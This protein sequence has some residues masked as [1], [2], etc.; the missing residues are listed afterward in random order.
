M[1]YVFGRKFAA[2]VAGTVVTAGWSATFTENAIIAPDDAAYDGQELVV[3]GCTVSVQG[4]HE[5]AALAVQ[6]PAGTGG[7]RL[8]FGPDARLTISGAVTLT[9]AST[10]VLGGGATLETGGR[11]WLTDPG[12]TVLVK[13]KNVDG[14]VGD[15]WRAAGATLR[16]RDV[17]VGA[18]AQITADA[19]GYV[20]AYG[21]YGLGPGAGGLVGAGGHGGAGSSRGNGGPAYGSALQPVEVGS[22][23]GGVYVDGWL[24]GTGG[25]G[26]GAI[27]LVVE[28]ELTL[29]GTISANAGPGGPDKFGGGAGGSLWIETGRLAGHGALRATGSDGA[30]AGGGGGGGRIAVYYRE[31]AEYAGFP[32][33]TVAG[34]GGGGEPSGQPGTLGFFDVSR[35][36]G[37]PSLYVP[38]D[39][40]AYPPQAV[41]RL[42]HVSVGTTTAPEAR[43]ELG[44]GG[45]FTADGMGITNGLVRA[46]Q[47]SLLNW[48]G[49]VRLGPAGVFVLGGGSTLNVG[50]TLSLPEPTSLLLVQA[51]NVTGQVDGRWQAVGTTIQAS[52]VI[53]SSGARISADAQGYVGAYGQAGLGPGAN[54]AVGAGG[55]G[56]TGAAAGAGGPAYGS[57]LQ[58]RDVGSSGG[59]VYVDGWRAGTGGTGGGAIHLVVRNHLT[60]DG[61]ISAN[62]GPGEPDKF[63]GGAGGSLWVETGTLEGGGQ[64]SATGS[65]GGEHSGGGGGGRIAVYYRAATA[66]T[67]YTNATV[68]AGGGPAPG[69]P[70]T[71]LFADISRGVARPWFLVPGHRFEFPAEAA[72]GALTLGLAG[73]T[74]VTLDLP[75]DGV[76]RLDDD[77][78]VAN[79]TVL[80]LGGGASLNVGGRL[81]I[82]DTN[83]TILVLGK[84]IYGPVDG[85]WAG[86]GGTILASEVTIG[87]GARLTAD[88]QGYNGGYGYR[89]YG[90]GAN[91][92]VGG[93][94]HGGRGVEGGPTYGSADFPVDLGSAGGGDY[95]SGWF[96]GTGGSGGGALR[97]AVRNTLVVDGALTVNGLDAGWGNEAGGGAGGSLWIDARALGGGGLISAAGGLGRSRAGGGGRI[98]LYSVLRDFPGTITVAGGS[99]EVAA[100]EGTLVLGSQPVFRWAPTMPSAFHGTQALAWET[101]AVDTRGLTVTITASRNGMTYTVGTSTEVLLGRLDWDT[102]TVPD[103]VHELR[104]IFR[105]ATG[106]VV[107]DLRHDALVANTAAVVWHSGTLADDEVWTPAAMHVVDRDLR[108]PPGVTL[109]L[110]P[111]T[112]V[113]ILDGVTLT[114]ADTATLAAPGAPGLP[115]ILTSIQDD[116]AGGDTNQDG[117]QTRP[118]PGSWTWRVE[119]TGQVQVNADTLRRYY[120]QAHAGTL[121]GDETWAGT[122]LHLVAQD[123]SIPAG[124]TLTIEPGAV[125]KFGRHQGLWV[126]AGATLAAP[127]TVAQPITFTSLADATAGG[128][129]ATDRTAGPPGAGDWRGLQLD[130]GKATLTHVA[131]TYAG[132]TPA[133]IW[134]SSAGAL[135]LRNGAAATLT[136]CLVQDALFDGILA[137]GSGDV[138]LAGTVVRNCDRAVNADHGSRVTLRHCVLDANRIGI[139]GHGG[140]VD[141]ANSIISRSAEMG[142][143]NVLGS[144]FA[145]R[146]SDV[147]STNGVNY[148]GTL[149]DPTGSAGNL[150]ADPR[151]KNPVAGDYRLAYR[152][153][154]IDAADG[155]LAPAT[156]A[157]GAPRYSDPRTLVKT[158]TPAANGAFPDLGA[159]EFVES[160]DSPIDLVVSAI[161]APPEA[162]A[163]DPVTVVWTVANL[164][165]AT[166]AGPWHDALS[167]EPE[168][169]ADDETGIP[170]AEVL[171]EAALGPGQSA[172]FRATVRMPGGTEGDWRWRV[173]TNSRGELFEGRNHD[174]NT[175]LAATSTRLH[176]PILPV[177]APVT[178]TFADA[179][180]PSW[181]RVLQPAGQALSV[182][183]DAASPDGRC[184]LYAG[185]GQMPAAH[186]YSWRS[187]AWNSPDAALTI[188]AAAADRV[189]Y[190]TVQPEALAPGQPAFT[191]AVQPSHFALSRLGL[192]SAGNLGSVTL[193][194]T[195]DGF[196]PLLQAA[197]HPATGPDVPAG[198]VGVSSSLDA[199]A[200]FDLRGVPPGVYSVVLTQAG[201]T[202]LLPHAF[203]VTAGVGGRL[204]TRLMLPTAAR[205]GRPFT[206]S[207]EYGNSGDADLAAP[208]LQVSAGSP[209]LLLWEPDHPEAPGTALRFLA[210]APDGLEPGVLRPASSYTITLRAQ[211]NAPGPANFGL[212]VLDGGGPPVD[213]HA[214]SQQVRPPDADALW[215]NAWQTV[216]GTAG[217]T[218][219][220]YLRALN[221][222]ATRARQYTVNLTSEAELLEFL[223]EE[224]QQTLDPAP[225]AGRLFLADT[226]HP[227]ARVT[228]TLQLRDSAPGTPDRLF[229][230]VTWYDGRF[231]MRGVLPGA[232]T[233]S[234]VDHLPEPLAELTLATPAD[235]TLTNLTLIATTPGGAIVGRVVAGDDTA[236]VSG[237]LL[238]ADPQDGQPSH[239]ALTRDDGSYRIPGLAPG[240][241]RLA[242]QA[243]GHLPQPARLVTVQAGLATAQSYDLPLAGGRL[244]GRVTRPD[245]SAAAGAVVAARW[246]GPVGQ[247]GSWS[248]GYATTD[249][250][251][252]YTITGLPPGS[253]RLAAS[254]ANAGVS[255]ITDV[256][257]PDYTAAIARDLALRW[258]ATLS[259]T[260][261][262]AATR[263]PIANANVWVRALPAVAADAWT[264]AAGRFVLTGLGVDRYSVLASADG[265]L[266]V[267]FTGETGAATTPPVV[268]E[269]ERLGGVS[270]VLRSQGT[271]QRQ[272][273][274]T[275]EWAGGLRD[276]VLTDDTGAYRFGTLPPGAYR[277]G[278][279]PQTGLVLWGDPF[280]IAT[281]NLAQ[282]TRDFAL[283]PAGSVT[284]RT[285]AADGVTA[286]TNITVYLVSAGEVLAQTQTDPA[287]AYGFTVLRPGTYRLYAISPT[288]WLTPPAEFTLDT[289][290]QLSGVDLVAPT[291]SLNVLIIAQADGRPL[292]QAVVTLR[293]TDAPE[294]MLTRSGRT[295]PDGSLLLPQVPPGDYRLSASADGYAYTEIPVSPGTGLPG[296]T[297]PLPTGRTIQGVVRADGRPVP[298]V[299][300][301]VAEAGG[302]LMFATQTDLQGHYQFTSLPP[303]LVDLLVIPARDYVPAVEENV[304]TE[305]ANG[306][307]TDFALTRSDAGAETGV[308][309]DSRGAPAAGTL[310]RL[311]HSSGVAV[312]AQA[313]N[314]PD[315]QYRLERCP[316]GAFT[317]EARSPGSFPARLTV[318]RRAGSDSTNA[319]LILDGPVAWAS[320]S[321]G[322]GRRGAVQLADY[323]TWMGG[324]LSG[325]SPPDVVAADALFDLDGFIRY[326]MNYRPQPC[327]V[328]IIP[329]GLPFAIK[330][331][332]LFD[333]WNFDYQLMCESINRD[334]LL[335]NAAAA[336][337]TA[338]AILAAQAI[339]V[340]AAVATGTAVATAST[341]VWGTAL[342]SSIATYSGIALGALNAILTA[343]SSD[344]EPAAKIIAINGAVGSVLNALSQLPPWLSQYCSGIAA[345]LF[346]VVSD[347][348]SVVSAQQALQED[349][350]RWLKQ[351]AD[352]ETR[353]FDAYAEFQRHRH[354]YAYTYPHCGGDGGTNST[355]VLQS[356]DPNAKLTTG[357][358]PDHWVNRSAPITYTIEFENVPTATAAAQQVT[359]TDQ[360]APELDWSTFELLEVAFNQVVVPVP[361]GLRT[362]R[363]VVPVATDPNPVSLAATLNPLTGIATWTLT[364]V[365]PRTGSLVEDPLAG[366]LPPNTPDHRGEGHVTFSIRPRPDLPPGTRILNEARIVF[367]VN[368]PIPTGTVTNTVAA[369]SPASRVA[370][371]PPLSPPDIPVA[372]NGS[373]ANGPGIAGYDLYVSTDGSP[374]Q[375]WLL[376]VLDENA[377]FSGQPGSA[378]AFVSLAWDA[379]GN[380]EALPDVPDAQT[381]VP[382]VVE[383]SAT[384]VLTVKWRSVPG[385]AYVVETTPGTG[386]DAVW[387]AREGPVVATEAVSTFIETHPGASG[388]YRVQKLATP[389]RQA[390]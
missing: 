295:A 298:A 206:V 24:A 321:S 33:C 322:E 203:T 91:G 301:Y 209:S 264:D 296:V 234:A 175:L 374:Y 366:F 210:G 98:A 118:V 136:N 306:A 230:A 163:G 341:A 315:G 168:N 242:I 154:C 140:T 108:V 279:G 367:D 121:A 52:N 120:L 282:I 25:T 189:I 257:V 92:P 383:I 369:G 289:N 324:W 100:Q 76:L 134:D 311:V 227:L 259:G 3:L 330:A 212:R 370:P 354:E 174:N 217:P 320:P 135:A 228:V 243:N 211:A 68:A 255:T 196:T 388:F 138:T 115:I 162:T 325:T 74:P 334:Q 23:G 351:C 343:V 2:L 106:R 216:V 356:S 326:W 157:L 297:L 124:A 349:L 177:G 26:G 172:T 377:V 260:V 288:G 238:V 187:E 180:A 69:Q 194:L 173:R 232:Y 303:G 78:T 219:S 152:S 178:R 191:L 202:A 318:H 90:P 57:S 358:G 88:G 101:H 66:F 40:F 357:H 249:D 309:Q 201:S 363:A 339:R 308:V 94:S 53:V 132:G 372:W 214:L 290:R 368:A 390:P 333:P 254:L 250:A 49:D 340:A 265:Y 87:P 233:V 42:A 292:D 237:A 381:E 61:S 272:V 184:T 158:G 316:A 186:A 223:V 379:L 110:E 109:T 116:T 15:A 380:R 166:L 300:V 20:G 248:G 105:D 226:Q 323:K 32:D 205:L 231:Q 246:A 268:V 160:A 18:G 96:S 139:W 313:A 385:R 31:A 198:W 104:A 12:S 337:L 271:P 222:A 86:A 137:W 373:P 9:N 146:A 85:R 193:P 239:S 27:H 51:R 244:H 77:L 207:V 342:A 183:L 113:K 263:T 240:S 329:K 221:A 83:S 58:P 150:S 29:E 170:V 276:E 266:P 79:G 384:P 16:A 114:I 336:G 126:P 130:G 80:T 362:Y 71:L 95:T 54:G 355:D 359:I 75:A 204:W 375:P 153:P 47:G 48:V 46:G 215:T 252:A 245:G 102:S 270:G 151:F 304:W 182:T 179:N 261:V 199:A 34:G 50:G 195:G 352:D 89:G 129:G 38:R 122:L 378:Y 99:G 28:N 43:L 280:V 346:G 131:I 284:G 36:N 171:A 111:G 142:V 347:A 72:A 229:T 35:D 319:A 371:L 273:P 220:D 55:H 39:R 236:P 125:V 200:R 148:G 164:G 376:R 161:Q 13:G 350:A 218:E 312:A 307:D 361:P 11:L 112:V 283:D 17:L 291:H 117:P 123:V 253:Y 364:S 30:G 197:L 97:L 278:V 382:T 67:G 192:T 224:A 119:G 335:L 143:A 345:P 93:G 302:T 81:T 176:V 269:L 277:I 281:T 365:D 14:K 128:D 327:E 45:Q 103:G 285:L 262:D 389:G 84:N 145:I 5:F 328:R 70:G 82:C 159:F 8:E 185:D 387:V 73:G 293:S 165:T 299:P 37:Q 56:G 353:F 147:W 1:R 167:L 41:V 305:L 188:P 62:A 348:L 44:D 107:A 360:L 331:R 7:A 10:L 287:G 251:G 156:D 169:P 310:V 213:Y 155:A 133:G 141:L 63:G 338:D 4:V 144:A 19:Q 225:V 247:Y 208:L 64:F 60:L 149:G 386:P 317:L 235:S 127:G 59:G 286:F 181:Y 344:A 190:L 267:R 256:T 21:A 294:G 241:Y 275:L 6:D 332:A 314:P 274:I 22:S 65:D 258:G